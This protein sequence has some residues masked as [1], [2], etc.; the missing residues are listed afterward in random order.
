VMRQQLA[1]FPDGAFNCGLAHGV[2]GVVALLARVAALPETSS[3]RVRDAAADALGW[4]A[5]R[6][7]G[8][9]GYP[10]WVTR[11]HASRGELTRTAWCYGDA[12]V[13]LATWSAASRLGL[14]T[15]DALAL[16]LECAQ[17]PPERCGVV[18]A[19]LCHGA[20]GLAHI[21][22]RFYQASREPRFRTAATAWFETALAMRRPDN[23]GIAGFLACESADGGVFV[24]EPMTNML[25][26]VIGIGLALLAAI[27]PTAPGWDRTML[28]EL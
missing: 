17:R 4:L 22:N 7:L 28:C 18:D 10:A 25:M 8:G 15:T 1:R 11:D 6:R 24:W 27:T 23:S 2:P 12:G 16:A 5:A 19:G 13:A 26:G 20:A 21:Y 3:D 14:A 9:G